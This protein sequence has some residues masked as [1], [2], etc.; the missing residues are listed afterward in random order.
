MI[1]PLWFQVMDPKLMEWAGGDITQG[2]R[3]IPPK[4]AQAVREVRRED[5][6]REAVKRP[7]TSDA[8]WRHVL[9]A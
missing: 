9:T 4:R 7:T 1:P 3:A 8:C 2:Q 6:R 5:V